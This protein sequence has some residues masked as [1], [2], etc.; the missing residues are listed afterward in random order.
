MKNEAEQERE[1]VGRER[2]RFKNHNFSV[3][4]FEVLGSPD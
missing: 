4:K 3:I 2:V 1:W